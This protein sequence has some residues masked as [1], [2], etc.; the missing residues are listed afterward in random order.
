MSV[1][2]EAKARQSGR[3][4]IRGGLKD[5]AFA[6]IVM[7][8]LGGAIFSTVLRRVAFIEIGYEIR[9]LEKTE[10]ELL[11]LQHEL[12]IEKAMLNSPERIEE[13]ARSRFGLKE[14]EPG[15]IRILP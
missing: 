13:V 1:A 10:S 6:L 5:F 9:Q 12:E 4:T 14:P 2:A 8:L 15:Q 7:L 3:I 11:R